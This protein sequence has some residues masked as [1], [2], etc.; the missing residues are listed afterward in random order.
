MTLEQFLGPY[1]VGDRL[2]PPALGLVPAGEPVAWG[3]YLI[4]PARYYKDAR[5][6]EQRAVRFGPVYG[7]TKGGSAVGISTPLWVEPS[8]R[9]TGLATEMMCWRYLADPEHWFKRRERTQT[10][11]RGGLAILERTYKRLCASGALRA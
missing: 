11:T 1:R 2:R 9:G 5:R 8:E 10:Y 6:H 4:F 3:C 7:A